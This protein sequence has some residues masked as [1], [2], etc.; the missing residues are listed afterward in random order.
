LDSR[1]GHLDLDL[2][3]LLV[4][5]FQFIIPL[6]EIPA[7][8]EMDLFLHILVKRYEIYDPDINI[9]FTIEA[10]GEGMVPEEDALLAFR[11]ELDLSYKGR[12][13]VKE[14]MQKRL[15]QNGI[16]AIMKWQ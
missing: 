7:E 5:S 3:I 13:E 6:Q 8:Q 15:K 9:Y 2:Y 16:A 14:S 11:H 12:R 4:L 1:H 10:T